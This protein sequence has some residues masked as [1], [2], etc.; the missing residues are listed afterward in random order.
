M[1]AERVTTRFPTLLMIDKAKQVV[2]DA[3]ASALEPL[4]EVEKQEIEKEALRQLEMEYI[5]DNGI[6]T[7]Q[8]RPGKKR[9]NGWGDK[10]KRTRKLARLA[11][12]C[13]RNSR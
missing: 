6:Q 13:T 9:P 4:T 8:N 1:N 7:A 10:R 5:L 3:E 11:R 12:K 2:K